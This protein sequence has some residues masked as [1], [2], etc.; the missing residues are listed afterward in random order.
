MALNLG[1]I[2]FGLGMDTAG[3]DAARSKLIQFGSAVESAAQKTGQGAAQA[4]AALKNQEKAALSALQQTLNLNNSLRQA[5]APQQLIDQV[6]A[7]YN[8]L[9]H[10]LTDVNATALGVH[11]AQADFASSLGN[12]RREADGFTKSSGGA[13]LTVMRD[14]GSA[15]TLSVG[16]LSGIGSRVVALTDIFKRGSLFTAGLVASVILLGFGVAAVVGKILDFVKSMEQAN[17]Q[18]ES[19]LGSTSAAAINLRFVGDIAFKTGADFVSLATNFGKFLSAAEGA[20]LTSTRV[21]KVFQDLTTAGQGLQ[22]KGD[23]LNNVFRLFERI[24]STDIVTTGELRR[25]FETALPGA[26]AKAA[27]AFNMT[28]Q[29]FELALQHGSISAEAFVTRVSAAL[30]KTSGK[31]AGQG[32]E[33]Q[34]NKLS[35]ALAQLELQIDKG[36]GLSDAFAGAMENGANSIKAFNDR[37]EEGNGPKG[38]GGMLANLTVLF[39]QGPV[40]F[41]ALAG[42]QGK[43]MVAS[44]NATKTIDE[45]IK[46]VKEAGA[47]NAA[48]TAQ[49]I[50]WAQKSI[51][52]YQSQSDAAHDY[53]KII[54][55]LQADIEKLD[56]IER[57]QILTE[58]ASAEATSAKVRQAIDSYDAEIQ[59]INLVANTAHLGAGAQAELNTQMGNTS[60]IEK[61]IES[62]QKAGEWQQLSV[63]QQELLNKTLKSPNLSTKDLDV[64]SK[65]LLG[66]KQDAQG[67][68]AVI[69]LIGKM[70][71]GLTALNAR[72]Q[73]QALSTITVEVTKFKNATDEAAMSLINPA[74][75][76]FRKSQNSISQ[77]LYDAEQKFRAMNGGVSMT[78]TAVDALRQ[79]LQDTA[80]SKLVN[81]QKE[82]ELATTRLYALAAALTQ[83]KGS[84]EFLNGQF[85]ETDQIKS[86][87]DK[88]IAAGDAM[89]MTT[90]QAKIFQAA[91]D[92]PFSSQAVD[93]LI[94]L[95]NE[96][97]ASGS[98]ASRATTAVLNYMNALQVQDTAKA[99]DGLK[100]INQQIERQAALIAAIPK[101]KQ[102]MD[103]LKQE[104]DFQDEVRT[105]TDQIMAFSVGTDM[106]YEKA[107]NLATVLAT[108]KERYAQLSPEIKDAQELFKQWASIV[109]SGAKQMSDDIVSMVTSMH[110]S[111]STLLQDFIKM[112]NDMISEALKMAIIKPLFESIF[113]TSSGGGLLGTF[114]NSL[115]GSGGV[116]GTSAGMSFVGVGSL[117]GFAGGGDVFKGTPVVVGEHGPEIFVPGANGQIISNDN[118]H[119]GVPYLQ[120]IMSQGNGTNGGGR[121]QRIAIA[122]EVGA[123]PE[124]D[125]RMTS[126]SSKTTQV[127]I[128]SYDKRTLPTRVASLTNDP[129]KR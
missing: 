15:A 12:V 19:L 98:N 126:I 48:T 27:T 13:M 55:I 28:T 105:T 119:T 7:A 117:P 63:Q 22:L 129:R 60:G 80:N 44:T 66:M 108:L 70:K 125:V 96:L 1:Q 111:F 77:A 6:N 88:L 68:V 54:K 113:G 107:Q 5:G 99:A 33:E 37:V 16:P 39:T 124:F 8:R 3:L 75:G 67:P 78:K 83:S 82:S 106:T 38:L 42:A 72:D 58:N 50:Q 59:K 79:S 73:A 112:I 36:T 87:A 93:G 109:D 31:G 20:R 122:F 52:S 56:A 24:M 51:D 81:L 128:E 110:F 62:L 41:L 49:A 91:I 34:S 10:T 25:Q 92:H 97:V 57:A 64:L 2:N 43:Q 69:D 17:A 121:S 21:A 103:E 114:I 84:M 104:F 47:G 118:L 102:A 4:A 9:N 76:E 71:T 85:Q 127:G 46:S 100:N 40:A 45:Y 120:D 74:W 95:N 65:S 18:L 26:F 11:R 89:G 23:D 30:A 61:M 29:Q 123:T 90:A 94:K 101:G 32:L 35:T 86:Y 53:S 14:I 115:L 116:G